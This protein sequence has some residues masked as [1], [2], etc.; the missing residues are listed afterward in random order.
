MDAKGRVKLPANLLKQLNT[1]GSYDFVINRGH[2]KNLILYPH[3]VWEKKTKQLS[4]LDINI[5]KIRKAVRYF[6]RGA[7]KVTSDGSERILLPKP[8]I[9]Y[10]GIEKEVVLLA[11]MDQ[12]EIWSREEYGRMIEEEPSS[13]GA[14]SEQLNAASQSSSQEDE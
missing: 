5:E 8:L 14:L 3:D 7:T 9:Q 10:A 1:T 6:F 11:F 4:H 2:E 12:I 13:L